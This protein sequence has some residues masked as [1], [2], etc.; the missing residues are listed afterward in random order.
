MGNDLV[1]SDEYSIAQ[2]NPEATGAVVA[3]VKE[4][5][6]AIILAK[7]FPRDLDRAWESLMKHCGRQNMAAKSAYAFPRGGTK[8]SGPSVYLARIAKQAWGNMRSGVRI[9]SVTDEE[10]HLEGWA[11]DLESNDHQTDPAYFKKLVQ[12]R[13][14]GATQWVKPDERDLRE[15]M[16][17]HG[18]LAERNAILKLM[19]PDFIDDALAASRATLAKNIK[20]PAHEKKRLILEFSK[21]GV[22]VEM[23]QKY[24]DS[25]EWGPED[26]VDL[27]GILNSIMDGNSKRDDYF[28]TRKPAPEQGFTASLSPD[29]IKNA[30]PSTHQGHNLAGPKQENKDVEQD[31]VAGP[32]QGQLAI[33]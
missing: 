30:D 8:V 21:I 31:A 9:L 7:R 19:P 29:Q 28:K 1:I 15:L 23:L 22:T 27:V 17:K 18:A 25:V 6:A 16:N 33:K 3:R 20:D 5:E 13:V 2:V 11:W 24:L 26:L 12:R 14:D 32:E 4:I 10:V